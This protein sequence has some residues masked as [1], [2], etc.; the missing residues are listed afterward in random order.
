MNKYRDDTWICEDEGFVRF[1][2][3]LHGNLSE[4][5]SPR[6]T[7]KIMGSMLVAFKKATRKIV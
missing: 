6:I 7:R 5:G 1:S 4:L 2:W 3:C